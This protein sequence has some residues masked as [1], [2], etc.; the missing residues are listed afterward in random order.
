[1]TINCPRCGNFLVDSYLKKIIE[2]NKYDY[3]FINCDCGNTIKIYK[4]DKPEY[5]YCFK[6]G[7]VV[8]NLIITTDDAGN[9][10]L[11]DAEIVQYFSLS[12]DKNKDDM[13]F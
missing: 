6:T 5:E 4:S 12:D 10:V 9:T 1:M 11:K 7:K 2:K 8:K 3:W 13:P